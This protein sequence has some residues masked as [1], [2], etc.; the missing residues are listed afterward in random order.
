MKKLNIRKREILFRKMNKLA[1]KGILS[2]E[3]MK[4]E[5]DTE[6]GEPNLYGV[7]KEER[8]DKFKKLLN[9]YFNYLKTNEIHQIDG[10]KENSI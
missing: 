3:A 4:T 9:L 6:T 10:T 7:T 2:D 8:L 5:P 1:S